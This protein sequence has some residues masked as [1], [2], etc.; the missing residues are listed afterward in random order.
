VVVAG[1]TD[2]A[3]AVVG[4]AEVFDAATLAPRAVVPMVVPRTGAVARPLDSGQVLIVGGRDALGAPVA[5]VEL[6]TPG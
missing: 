4:T 5:T 1:G 2:G 3:G 6:F